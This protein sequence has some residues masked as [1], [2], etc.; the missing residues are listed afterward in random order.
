MTITSRRPA[1]PARTERVLLLAIQTPIAL[2]LAT[3]L[4]VMEP[5]L[6]STIYPAIV[7]KALYYRT[8]IEIASAVWVVLALRYPVYRTPRSL[9]PLVFAAFVAVSLLSSF[10]GVSTERSLWSTYERMQGFVDLAHWLAFIWVVT[11]VFRYHSHWRAL[12]NISLAVSLV[13]GLLG[14]GEY[15]ST[16]ATR[17][18]STLGNATYLGGYMLINLMVA[19]AFLSHSYLGSG[20]PKSSV[21]AKRIRKRGQSRSVTQQGL[22]PSSENSLRAF[23]A[24]VIV[25]DASILYLSGTRGAFVG[26][27]AG[28]VVV[29]IGYV[30]W[31]QRTRVR[32][33][34][35]AIVTLSVLVV[36]PLAPRAIGALQ[37]IAGS[38]T[39]V[40]RIAQTGSRDPSV[41][42]RV[43]AV[44]VGFRAFLA[45]P[46]LGWGQENF[47]IAYDRHITPNIEALSYDHRACCCRLGFGVIRDREFFAVTFSDTAAA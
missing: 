46:I 12:L 14:L 22:F 4:I 30:I 43:G 36:A 34:L 8:L 1:G 16:S 20:L 7:G 23:W 42:I 25:L 44:V 5:P 21:P 15:L 10:F 41:R 27:A 17:L 45:R 29:A 19:L 33:A 35:F 38:N 9:L 28:L 31:G 3:P 6:P 47:N 40:S 2:V 32:Q 24:T 39:A 26:L 13:V 18:S 11:T 37:E